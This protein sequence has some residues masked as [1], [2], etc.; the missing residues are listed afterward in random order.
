MMMMMMMVM[1]AIVMVMKMNK[2]NDHCQHPTTSQSSNHPRLA[3][4]NKK[5]QQQTNKKNKQTNRTKPNPNR[6]KQNKNKQTNKN[7]TIPNTTSPHSWAPI[8]PPCPH[9]FPMR[10]TCCHVSGSTRPRSAFCRWSM[11]KI[12]VVIAACTWEREIFFQKVGALV[13]LVGVSSCLFMFFGKDYV[14]CFCF[15]VIF[16]GV[17]GGWEGGDL[18]A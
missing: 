12:Q 18:L 8:H 14:P 5:K 3:K 7:K 16:P 15:V 6:T 4:K 13:G 17:F 11:A 1:M 2:L 10:S 9:S